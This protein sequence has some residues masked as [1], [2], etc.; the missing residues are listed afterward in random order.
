[1]CS[2][3]PPFDNIALVADNDRMYHR[4]GWVGDPAPPPLELSARAEIHH[5]YEGWTIADGD[6]VRAVYPDEWVRISVLWKAQVR[7]PG[8][9]ADRPAALTPERV[10][11]VITA[12]LRE[13][14]VRSTAPTS[15]LTDEQWIALVHASYYPAVTVDR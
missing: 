11:E 15:P 14:G 13:R 2:E 6:R 1:M 7:A 3:R 4:I 9:A 10:A 8:S 12:D 5:G